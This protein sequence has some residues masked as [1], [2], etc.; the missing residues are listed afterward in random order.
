MDKLTSIAVGIVAWVGGVLLLRAIGPAF[1]AQMPSDTPGL[2]IW[3]MEYVWL[4]WVVFSLIAF[5]GWARG[6]MQ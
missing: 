5:I 4:L 1:A 2:L 6:N 3:S